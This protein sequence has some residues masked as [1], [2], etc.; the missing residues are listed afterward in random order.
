MRPRYV[1]LKNFLGHESEKV[2][3]PESGMFFLSGDSGSGKS[4]FIVDAIGY[5][6]FGSKATRVTRQEQLRHKDHQADAMEV[7]V[8]F[9]FD[10]GSQMLLAR[11]IT[12]KGG[13]WAEVHEVDP[14]APT[15]T[16]LLADTVHR[17]GRI[18]RQRL[19]GLTWQQFYAA[20]VARQSEIAMLTELK[21]AA[22]KELVHRLLG[23]R[24]LERSTEEVS[25]RLRAVRTQ[26]KGLQGQLGER[27]REIEDARSAELGAAAL[28]QKQLAES[29][30]QQLQELRAQLQVAEAEL[31]P[32]EERERAHTQMLQL[33]S[34]LQSR[35]LA[36]T[37]LSKSV[38]R[39]RE[40]A[41]M[42]AHKSELEA[43]V[44]ELA[45]KYETLRADYA[46]AQEFVKSSEELARALARVSELTPPEIEDEAEATV[47][48][49]RSRQQL[50]SAEV[51]RLQGEHVERTAELTRLRETGECFVCLRPLG[52]PHD[53]DRVLANLEGKLA[54]LA[55]TESQC[56]IEL[57]AIAEAMPQAQ[58]REHVRAASERERAGAEAVLAQAQAHTAQLGEESVDLPELEARGRAAAS[59]LDEARTQLA[60]AVAATNGLDSEAESKATALQALIADE[61]TQ[62]RAAEAQVGANYE[63]QAI[64]ER[65]NVVAAQR[66]QVAAAEGRVPELFKQAE[67]AAA[68]HT[69]VERELASLL[70]K[71]E[72]LE[73]VQQQ[74]LRLEDLQTYIGGFQRKLAADIRPALEEMGS[75]MLDQVSGGKHVAMHIDDSYE[76]EVQSAEGSWVPSVLLSGGELIRVNI[77]L[78]LALTRLVSQRT[79]TPARFLVLDEPLPSQDAG[80]VQRIMELLDSLR[81]FYPQ[82]YIISHV[83]DLRSANEVDYVFDFE[84]SGAERI[85]LSFA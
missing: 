76:I 73:E 46:R 13:P 1:E 64:I 59:E 23:M 17:V 29:E 71:L 49:L 67:A 62:L 12:A 84:A 16:I 26:L 53:H 39:H 66:Q 6:L 83:G 31:V 52:E 47:E 35:E 63:E 61:Q 9:E 78:R 54:E 48:A 68:A 24:E 65:R 40:A 51:T 80:H 7:R 5:S 82:I 25:S 30:E 18:V 4:S 69:A 60:A 50:L 37:E 72:K 11:G 45:S 20:F 43:V 41:Q 57:A 85:T 38:E 14:A 56:E 77:C 19:G 74:V 70:D 10:D 36:L 8:L 2:S 79:G 42:I 27:T 32:E 15:Q 33:R 34:S 75:E 81:P 21:G 58:E 55:S 22:R 44:S 3:I 28:T